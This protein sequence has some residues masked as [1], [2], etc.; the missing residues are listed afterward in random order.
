MNRIG[1]DRI[2]RAACVL[3]D[4]NTS[5]SGFLLKGLGVLVALTC[6][7]CYKALPR[8]AQSSGE[9]DAPRGWPRLLWLATDRKDLAKPG[10][11]WQPPTRLPDECT[12]LIEV[13]TCSPTS[14]HSTVLYSHS[15][16]VHLCCST[17]RP[18][19]APS[20]LFNK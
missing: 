19:S 20:S 17:H 4:A 5:Y 18:N 7:A 2:G 14:L 8:R 3:Q 15:R 1:L 11:D 9:I 16:T 6:D 10:R 13:P 12:A